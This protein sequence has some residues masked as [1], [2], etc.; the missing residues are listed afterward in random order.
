MTGRSARRMAGQ[1]TD[2][3]EL[4]CRPAGE[5]EKQNCEQ[6]GLKTSKRR[7]SASLYGSAPRDPAGRTKPQGE[8][9][10]PD[11]GASVSRR[12]FAV[13]DFIEV[14]KIVLVS[15]SLYKVDYNRLVVITNY[16]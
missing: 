4:A 9:G 14:Y 16:F 5:K 10:W 13:P 3:E 6:K 12:G 8:V 1:S 2:R 7:T 11:R 15:R